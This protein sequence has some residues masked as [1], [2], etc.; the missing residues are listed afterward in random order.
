WVEVSE[1]QVISRNPDYILTTTMY[2]GTGP[3]PVEEVMSRVG[4]H[5][6]T[7]IRE[8]QVLNVDGD[9]FTVPGPR[10]MDALSFLYGYLYDSKAA[11]E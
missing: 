9:I 10:L 3:T 11:A 4:W 2:T 5:G 7:A 8:N 6:M 1:E